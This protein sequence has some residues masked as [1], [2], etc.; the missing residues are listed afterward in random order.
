M[1]AVVA[2]FNQE[3]ALVGAFSVIT[4]LRMELFEALVGTPPCGHLAA[5]AE[6]I[7]G[8]GSVIRPQEVT[9]SG[10]RGKED[11]TIQIISVIRVKLWITIIMLS[12]SPHQEDTLTITIVLRNHEEDPVILSGRWRRTSRPGSWW[13][14]VLAR[15]S[16]WCRASDWWSPTLTSIILDII[17]TRINLCP[18]ASKYWRFKSFILH[19]IS[20]FIITHLFK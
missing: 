6:N 8:R 4:N 12:S 20:P 17:L 18:Y 9:S 19:F 15:P 5:G 7:T 13:R 10:D 2:A 16:G 11:T 3:K 14:T 1:K